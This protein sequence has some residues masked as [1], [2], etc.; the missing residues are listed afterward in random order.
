M[1]STIILITGISIIL[2]QTK[3]VY[4]T[5]SSLTLRTNVFTA[6]NSAGYIL[7]T[8]S[9][10]AIKNLKVFVFIRNSIKLLM[11]GIKLFMILGTH[12][13]IASTMTG[14]CARI[15]S[16]HTM[17]YFLTVL[18]A[19]GIVSMIAFHMLTKSAT[20]WDT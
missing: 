6:A 14:I 9:T 16:M 5:V 1:Y 11:I 12:V 20:R 13:L 18:R 3:T 7:I 15:N 19:M 17:A 8:S 2:F 10:L 4:L